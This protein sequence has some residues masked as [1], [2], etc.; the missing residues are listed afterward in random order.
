[1]CR[2]S[3]TVSFPERG[4]GHDAERPLVHVGPRADDP[5]PAAAAA[6]TSDVAAV[7]GQVEVEVV[8]PPRLDLH[9]AREHVLVQ[10]HAHELLGQRLLRQG[11]NAIE[12]ISF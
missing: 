4:V 1:M 6:P 3:E 8:L 7:V 11:G 12:T 9:L 5:E 2:T 10:T